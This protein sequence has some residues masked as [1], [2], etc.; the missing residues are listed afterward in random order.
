MGCDIHSYAEVRKGD[1]WHM[2]GPT[3]PLDDF[4]RE[5]EK[6]THTEHPFDWRSYGMFGFLADV[7][8]Y[9]RV[10][11]I[12][13]P[14]HELPPDVSKE[15]RNEYGDDGDWHTATWLTLRQLI[16]FDY[17]QVFWDRRVTKQLTANSWT[18]AGLAEGGEGEH[19]TV[20]EFLGERFFR[21]LDLLKSL[22]DPDNVRVVFWFDN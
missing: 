4:G 22:G 19:L 13:D 2:V 21:D 10:P 18:G 8:N 14:K 15:I 20:R 12:A 16:E 17:D 1:Q 9:S 6:R 11:V 7:R 3:F 5:W